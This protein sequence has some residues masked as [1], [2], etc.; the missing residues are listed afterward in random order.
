MQEIANKATP[1]I[2][3]K[4]AEIVKIQIFL[5]ELNRLLDGSYGCVKRSFFPGIWKI[6]FAVQHWTDQHV[7]Y[8][9]FSI[10]EG[11]NDPLIKQIDAALDMFSRPD[12]GFYSYL[13]PTC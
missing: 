7:Q 3:H 5:D 11:K 1:L 12:V 10:E 9:L 2:G 6:G 13:V 8:R 4:S